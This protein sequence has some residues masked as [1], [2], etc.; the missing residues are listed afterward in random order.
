M[1]NEIRTDVHRPSEIVPSDYEYVAQEYL[2]V[3]DLGT[4][5]FLEAE[6]ARIKRHMEK[7]GG[8]YSHHEH[9]GNCMV[10]G[11]VNAIYTV[12]FYHAKTN[13]YVRM[14]SDCAMKC[15]MSVD[16]GSLNK[17][18]AAIEDARLAVAGKKKAAA[19]LA[20]R[21]LSKAWDLYTVDAVA[22]GYKYEEATINDIV[23]KLVK[24]GSVSDK[25]LD[26][27]KT[28]LERIETRAAKA[29]AEAA[30]LAAAL[31][32]PEGRM[33][34][35]GTVLGLKTEEGPYG[36]TTRML[37]KTDDGY[38]VWGSRTA[39]FE[40]GDRV[41]FVATVMPS[42]RDKKFGFFKRPTKGVVLSMEVAA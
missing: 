15:E 28:L 16:F 38:K 4:A 13:S 7:T 33:T 12:L 1:A 24:Y 3:E 29:A 18:R 34:I 23:G 19:I 10:C 40:K 41:S 25:S 14:G 20:D 22:A 42:D 31:D 21:G 5:L 26:F 8:T 32:C 2:K 27:V 30:E 6:R 36:V 37:V 35:T 9:G 17:F 39:N 11:S